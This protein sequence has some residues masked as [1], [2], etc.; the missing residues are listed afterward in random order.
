M[1]ERM[2]DERLSAIERSEHD[3]TYDTLHHIINVLCIEIRALKAELREKDFAPDGER[4]TDRADRLLKNLGEAYR[5]NSVLEAEVTRL[6]AA[7]GGMVDVAEMLCWEQLLPQGGVHDRRS[8][9][10]RAAKRALELGDALRAGK[11]G[12]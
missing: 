12:E 6:S 11:D 7:L 3:D 10:L 9:V 4:W 2:S 5:A 1:S 8:V